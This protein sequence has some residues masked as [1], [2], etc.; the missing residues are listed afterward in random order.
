[1][2]F[3]RILSVGKLHAK[4]GGTIMYK[5][6]FILIVLI[7]GL[8]ISLC[9]AENVTIKSSLNDKYGNPVIL[10][11]ILKKPNGKGTFPA[12]ILISGCSRDY[13]NNIREITWA[14]LL[15]SWGYVTI[16]PDSW[17]PRNDSGV[18]TQSEYYRIWADPI[19]TVE[20]IKSF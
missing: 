16:Q 20:I 5:K 3:S 19:L 15:V 12:V 11:A 14:D 2:P 9:F 8:L 13:Y 4:T 10:P 1:M 17:T 18:C 6:C 7:S